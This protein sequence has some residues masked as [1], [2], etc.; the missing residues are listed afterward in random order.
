MAYRFT[1]TGKW[2]DHW[3]LNLGVEGK[4][5]WNYLCDTCDICGNMEFIPKVISS[6]TGIKESEIEALTKGLGKGLIWNIDGTGFILRNYLKH[7]K[8]LPIGGSP[9]HKGIINRWYEI[10]HKFPNCVIDKV[11]GI[12]DEAERVTIPLP[13]PKHTLTIPLQKGYQ[14]PS[15]GLPNP[16]GKGKGKGNKEGGVGETIPEAPLPSPPKHLT[17]LFENSDGEEQTGGNRW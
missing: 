4:L 17:Q 9:F 5:L 12:T 15:I 3:Y 8:N 13:N 16:I 11:I 14:T 1:D 2:S 6:Q 10:S 7:Q